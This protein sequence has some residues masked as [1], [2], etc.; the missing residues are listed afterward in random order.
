MSYAQLRAFHAVATCGGFSKAADHLGLSQPAIS[1]QVRK[2]E[3]RFGVLLF[4]RHKRTVI[5]TDLG[6]R[7][8][9]V[10]RRHFEAEKE[11]LELLAESKALRT[12]QLNLAVDSPLHIIPL[13]G[14]FRERYPGLIV[15]L[16]IGNSGAVLARLLDYSA[17]VGV[18]AE[19]PPG[20][21]RLVVRPLR[22]DPLVAF[23]AADHP[24]ADRGSLSLRE[25]SE[26][27]LVLREPTS[28]TRRSI[29]N[30]LSRIGVRPRVAMI[31]E[32][33]E[34][35]REAVAA[36]IG[37]GVVSEPEFGRDER[38]RALRLTDS[39]AHMIEYLVCLV[40]RV[41]LRH[42]RALLDCVEDT[43]T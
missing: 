31:A 16:R 10:T 20:D 7:L 24:W 4:N 11:A 42:I 14:T 15:N 39:R 29:E 1:D 32:G 36:G 2:L 19:V 26:Q 22:D 21:D 18:M 30:E 41:H 6:E 27:P 35:A 23:V 37:M 5:L 33:R 9:V 8:L 12:G 28:T 34:A 43:S 38:L 13:L 3:E 17:D 40:E 25:L